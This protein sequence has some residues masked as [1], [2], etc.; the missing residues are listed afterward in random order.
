MSTKPGAIQ[1][2]VL[3]LIAEIES[4]CLIN[5][6]GCKPDLNNQ[7]FKRIN[8]DDVQQLI[9]VIKTLIPYAEAEASNMDCEENA[10]KGWIVF[11]DAHALLDVINGKNS[12]G[13]R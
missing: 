12:V 7:P 1:T 3:N 11:E 13:V 6:E 8:S 9:Q 4:H 2:A 5:K 10:E